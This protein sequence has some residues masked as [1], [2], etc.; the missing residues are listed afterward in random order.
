[1]LTRLAIGDPQPFTLADFRNRTGQERLNG[2]N[3][4]SDANPQ[5]VNPGGGGTAGNADLL[6]QSL[7]AYQLRPTS[8]LVNR[9]L[10][11]WSQFGIDPG[12]RDLF[13]TH[14]PSNSTGASSYLYD[15]GAGEG[16]ASA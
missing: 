8:P 5:L 10:N 16:A 13:G 14:L 15:V 11:L 3:T 6:E 12:R 1:M 4:G 7:G 9:G 2:V